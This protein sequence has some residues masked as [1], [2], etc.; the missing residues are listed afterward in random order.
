M[1]DSSEAAFQSSR[2]HLLVE[3]DRIR[4]MV[5]AA[6]TVED[7]EDEPSS[8]TPQ[9]S[10]EEEPDASHHA[11]LPLVLPETDRESVHDLTE[12]IETRC[13]ATDDVTLRVRRLAD[14]F[15]LS[16]RALDVLLLAVAPTV[17]DS[18]ETTYKRLQGDQMLSRPTVGLVESLFGHTTEEQLAAGEL[19]A[20]SSPLRAHGLVSLGDP[21][22]TNLS[23]RDRPITVDERIVEYLKGYDGLHQ[24]LVNGLQDHPPDV[25]EEPVAIEAPGTS[26]DELLVDDDLR[27]QLATI[28]DADEHGRRVYF[29]GPTGSGIHR[30]VDACSGSTSDT[31]LRADLSSVLE[32]DALDAL[33][34]EAILQNVPVHLAGADVAIGPQRRVD[35]SLEAV[36]RR[37]DAL[38]RDL[39]ITGTREW[40]PTGSTDALVDALVEFDRPTITQRREFWHDQLDQLGI[41]ADA[42]ALAS[43]FDLTQGQLEAA[44]ATARALAGADELTAEHVRAGC[45]AQSSD[46]LDDLAQHVEPTKTWADIEL[47]ETTERQLRTLEAHITSRGR[48]YD[49]WGFREREGNAGVVALFKGL[50]GTGKTMAAE[51]LASAVGM[52][53]YK[54]DLSSVVSKYIGETEENLE[55][56]FEAAEQSNTILLFDEAD[57]IFGDRAEVSD[58]TDR[59]ANV[60]VNYLLQRI[61]TYDG[62]VV[63]TTNYAKN[64]DTAFARRI[65]HS[66]HFD[67][68]DPDARAAIWAGAFPDETPVEDLDTEWLSGF[69]FSGGDIAK[70]AKHIA[71]D[72]AERD[73]DAITQPLVVQ[74]IEQYKRDRDEPIRE[75]DFEP[76]IEH[77]AGETE[78]ERK[79]TLHERRRGDR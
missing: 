43:A 23:V 66:I 69:D 20:S 41:E 7:D 63:L 12:D 11:K 39:Y 38:D 36:V 71:I 30:A 51:V 42:E 54:I 61:E 33:V 58:A 32:A 67:R 64:M 24:A 59:Y 3:L 29:H 50:P 72:A 1:S 48:I 65:T 35:T 53:I 31:C 55:R 27:D 4:T 79:R 49:D 47:E 26:L 37:F 21:S 46:A 45:R 10:G 44:V 2:A 52:D 34:R 5:E 74:S 13:D 56:I 60:E 15:D 22:N 18:I 25:L 8:A 28:R 19:L 57:S 76:Y 73:V 17:D 62:I 70:L 78:R 77:L 40:T 68:P 16:R 6:A 14:G 75:D 9:D